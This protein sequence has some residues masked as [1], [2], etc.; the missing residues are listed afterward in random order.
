[1]LVIG[2]QMDHP[3]VSQTRHCVSTQTLDEAV[4]AQIVKATEIYSWEV[5]VLSLLWLGEIANRGIL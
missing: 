4:T 5:S 1:M 3:P 2:G